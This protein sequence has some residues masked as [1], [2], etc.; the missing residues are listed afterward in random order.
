MMDEVS[1]DRT[2]ATSCDPVTLE[3]VRGAL[4]A[5]QGE[6]EALIE[7]TAMSPFIR[8]K[9]DF[10]AAL[11]D[12]HGKLVI[13]TNLPAFGGIVEPILERYPAATMSEGDLYWYNDCY[14][15]RGAVS[16][17]PDQVFVAPVYCEGELVA[18]THSW[19]HFN[20][21]GGMRPGS[22]SSDCTDIFQEGIIIPPIRLMRDGQT[23]EEALRI[24]TR[25]SRFPGMIRGDLRATIAAV[26]L[27]ERRLGELFQ[28]FGK[29]RMLDAFE[30]LI[31]RTAIAMK[32]RLRAQIKPG[33]YQFTDAV[34][35][36]GQGNG[37]LHLRY[38]LDVAPD[39]IALDATRSDDQT[40]GPV[41]F[42]M[43]PD[44]PRTVF[45][46][47]F[48][49]GDSEHVINDG[50]LRAIDEVKLRE[51]S[52]VQ[53]RYPAPLG[54]RGVTLMRNVAACLGLVNVAT[55]G[56]APASHCAYVIWHMR[57]RKDDGSLFLMS[58]GVGVGYGARPNADGIDTVYLVAQENYP[59]EFLDA[60][61]PVRLLRY[62]VNPDTG[63]PGRWRGGCGV[64]R[65]IE[66]LAPEAMISVRIDAVDNPPWGVRGGRSGRGGGCIV[67]PGRPDERRVRNI[68]DGTIVKRGDVIR[69]ETGGGGGWGHP[70]DREPERVLADLRGGFVTRE[71]AA[72]DYGVVLTADDRAIDDSATLARRADRPAAAMFHRKRYADALD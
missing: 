47:Y 48:V 40:P 43:H 33:S 65:E 61:Y 26:R 67:N 13:G 63:G 9:K 37:P 66:L 42:L 21:V 39:R 17:T 15:S 8:E 32:E 68:S 19:A 29:A 49:G 2:T 38:T 30:Q 69:I 64:I 53:P 36:D 11:F 27:G 55:G 71:S 10:F 28:R 12:R 58:D 22:L 1:S 24:F 57:G 52:F 20:D 18:F 70:Y 62:A 56:E 4:R 54:M 5:A 23:N 34:D 60:V 31:Q 14:G 59:A 44:V 25:N 7:R 6:M 72:A 41:N 16:H 35:S 3:I 45:G 46:L 50:V 51:G